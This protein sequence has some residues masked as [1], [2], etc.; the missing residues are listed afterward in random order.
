MELTINNGILE[1]AILAE[2]ETHV[3]VPGG[4]TS[5][6]VL[7]FANCESLTSITLSDGVTSIGRQAFANCRSLENII[8]PH[9]VTSIGYRAFSDCTSLM[10]VTIPD[11]ETS[12]E[13][14]FP[15]YSSIVS[16]TSV[17]DSAFRNCTSLT[18]VT[19]PDGVTTIEKHAFEYCH[20]LKN[21]TIPRSVTSIGHNA[22]YYCESLTG[23]T[24]PVGVTNIGKSTFCGCLSLVNITIPDGVT[25]VGEFAFSGCKSLAS[26][27]IPDG[28]T[29]IGDQAFAACRS[30]VSVTIPDSVTY[31]GEHVFYECISLKSILA[32]ISAEMFS[33]QTSDLRLPLATGY[34]ESSASYDKDELGYLTKYCKSQVK[35]LL[36]LIMA[37]DNVAAMNGYAEIGGI[38]IKNYETLFADAQKSKAAQIIAFLLEYRGKH[39][40]QEDFDKK[41]ADVK[42]ASKPL[43]AAELEKLLKKLW[44]TYELK[45]GTISVKYKG[46]EASVSIPSQIET[47]RVTNIGVNAFHGC[48][49]LTSIT[50]PDSVTYIGSH[51]FY[52]CE[53]LTSITIPDSVTC[54]EDDAF[55]G[56][57]SGL[58]IHGSAGS[59]AEQYTAR[60]RKIKFAAL[61]ER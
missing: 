52:G 22:F 4:V 25:S 7:A 24:I 61:D 37:H 50:I 46:H 36:P 44:I 20:S 26:V 19:L 51:A 14:V 32:R 47:K 34:L 56:C 58:T 35:H 42:K 28:V 9:S 48:E 54:I 30:L 49:S 5:I 8:I 40:T 55:S 41:A 6:G 21:V 29:S 10:S 13:V 27:T 59:Y 53:S 31:I 1:K 57:A 43:S 17:G 39:F 38:T 60:R 23:I 11:D 3:D 18:N 33:S 15:C 45:D 12:I 2:G 16:V